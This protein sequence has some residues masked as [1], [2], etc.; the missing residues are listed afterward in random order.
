MIYSDG[1]DYRVVFPEDGGQFAVSPQD[2]LRLQLRDRATWAAVIECAARLRYPD[3][4]AADGPQV[5]RPKIKTGLDLLTGTD[6]Q[7]VRP[8]HGQMSNLPRS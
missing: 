6:S 1:T 4:D 8:K 5:N 7:F 2:L 3:N